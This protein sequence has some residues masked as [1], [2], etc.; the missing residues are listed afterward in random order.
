MHGISPEWP[1]FCLCGMHAQPA[2]N[3]LLPRSDFYVQPKEVGRTPLKSINRARTGKLTIVEKPRIPESPAEEQQHKAIK[4]RAPAPSSTSNHCATLDGAPSEEA[5]MSRQP[6]HGAAKDRA[7]KPSL[8][9]DSSAASASVECSPSASTSSTASPALSEGSLN[10]HASNHGSSRSGSAA[11]APGA[12]SASREGSPFFREC[13]STH[14]W[15]SSPDTG[16]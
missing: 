15:T 13:P 10:W 3:T 12:V 11:P 8:S 5:P 4:P 9:V 16:I 1:A 2:D 7:T 14:P 6:I